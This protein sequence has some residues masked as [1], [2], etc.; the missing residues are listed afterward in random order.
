MSPEERKLLEEELINLQKILDVYT[1]FR[2]QI[3]SMNQLEIDNH[4]DDILD[5]FNEIKNTL[6]S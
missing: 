2:N 3:V 6:E 5:R 1:D 4:I